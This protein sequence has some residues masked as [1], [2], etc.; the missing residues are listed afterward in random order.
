MFKE[1]IMFEP[2]LALRARRARCPFAA[3]RSQL[4]GGVM[5]AQTSLQVEAT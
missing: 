3:D 4:N 1:A 5:R 2:L